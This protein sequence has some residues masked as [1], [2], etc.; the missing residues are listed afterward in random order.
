[1]ITSVTLNKFDPQT[2]NE[3]IGWA[4]Q[5]YTTEPDLV[6]DEL[7]KIETVKDYPGRSVKMPIAQ[8]NAFRAAVHIREALKQEHPL[9]YLRESLPQSNLL[10]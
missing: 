4:A 9:S 8:F 7:I 2:L 6:R 5:T 1:M 10:D 3:F